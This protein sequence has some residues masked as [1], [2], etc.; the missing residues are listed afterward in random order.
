MKPLTLNGKRIS[1]VPFTDKHLNSDQYLFWLQDYEVI[2]YINRKEYLLPISFEQVEEY[3]SK[4]GKS[5]RDHIL[6]VVWNEGERFVGTFKFGALDWE[7]RTVNLGI[8]LGDR[9]FWGKGIAT[10]AF[11]LAVDYCFNGLGLRK[12]VAGCVAP[13]I[14]MKR[15]LEKLGF[16]Q[17]ACLRKQDF[18]EGKYV[19][20]YKFGLF[21]EEY[22]EGKVS[23]DLG[24]EPINL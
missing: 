15:V 22:R 23:E 18:I 9:D 3:V 13:N 20:H 21:E 19:D 8:L 12:I 4:I 14:G 10:E 17:E 7:N 16:K 24:N 11:E 2:K 6:A 5:S 1:L